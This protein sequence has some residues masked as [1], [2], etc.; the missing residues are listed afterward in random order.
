MKKLAL[1][2]GIFA[3]IVSVALVFTFCS[4]QAETESRNDVHNVKMRKGGTYSPIMQLS[5]GICVYVYIACIKRIDDTCTID[6]NIYIV[7]CED[8]SKVIDHGTYHIES[9]GNGWFWGCK[10]KCYPGH[11]GISSN[12]LFGLVV[13]PLFP[14]LCC[15][16]G[17][18]SNGPCDPIRS[19]ITLPSGKCVTLDITCCKGEI[20]GWFEFVDCQTGKPY[21]Q[22]RGV[23]CAKY[24]GDTNDPKEFNNLNN[25]D[26]CGDLNA[27][28][29][30]LQVLANVW[31][32]PC[33]Q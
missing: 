26:W 2:V 27:P 11:L 28:H 33:I 15:G 1:L 19:V 8:T 18:P 16:A 10:G 9:V 23:F 20:N 6:G 4:K 13:N 3:A 22:S 29:D 14:P 5:S 30:I 25:W 24:K 7:S 32:V 31:L 12:E 17:T 21:P